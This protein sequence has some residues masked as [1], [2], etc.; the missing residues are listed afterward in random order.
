[1]ARVPRQQGGKKHGKI[2]STLHFN[3]LEIKQGD[4]TLYCFKEKASKLWEFASI[5]RRE[6]DKDEGYQRVLSTSRVRAVADYI[7]DGNFIPGSIILGIDRGEYKNGR[8]RIQRGKD[9]AWV[10]DGQHRL[11]GA[12]LASTEGVDIE[13]SVIGLLDLDEEGRIDQF[14]TINREARNVPTSLY[15]D[16]LKLLP[17]RKTSAELA[18]ERAADVANTV[19][20]DK[21]SILYGKI[22]VTTSPKQGQISIVNFVRKLAPYVNPEKGLLNRFS[23][24]EQCK[25]VDNYF[26]ALKQAYPTEWNKTD[27]IFFKTIGF[28]A[29]MN[30]FEDVLK[31]AT[32]HGE[33][34]RVSD[35]AELFEPVKNFNFEQWREKGTG[36]KAESDA[37]RDFL[38]DFGR[39]VQRLR[40]HEHGKKILLD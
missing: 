31:E 37:A 25:I 18:S 23:L 20:H 19:R 5:N 40:E 21:S 28:G 8:L 16:L 2:P 27:S 15:L 30:V 26:L 35:V 34:F 1:M 10:I 38:I 13:L 12:H 33:G 29:I 24:N 11:A 14:V 7:L 9:V 3:A 6:E 36:N 22:V 4:H 17:R 39:A 32:M